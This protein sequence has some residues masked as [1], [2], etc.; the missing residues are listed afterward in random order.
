MPASLEWSFEIKIGDTDLYGHMNH[1]AYFSY[2]EEATVRFLNANGITLAPGALTP[3]VASVSCKYINAVH[4][5]ATIV[6]DGM[7]VRI[8][9]KKLLITHTVKSPDAKMIYAIAEK[10]MVW[11][12]FQ[13]HSAVDLPSYVVDLFPLS[14][15]NMVK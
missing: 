3:L 4:Y 7:G 6:I 8:S 15:K 9:P 11:F 5:P 2:I 1:V 14:E 12:D 13:K 10:V